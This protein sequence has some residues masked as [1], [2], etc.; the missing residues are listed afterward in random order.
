MHRRKQT[1]WKRT[2]QL[3]F[4]IS[5]RLTKRLMKSGVIRRVCKG[6]YTV[7]L[8][9][10]ECLFRPPAKSAGNHAEDPPTVD[11]TSSPLLFL[12]PC[13]RTYGCRADLA[14]FGVR[15]TA[16]R[17]RPT[18]IRHTSRVRLRAADP[19]IESQANCVIH[20]PSVF[21]GN[22]STSVQ[23]RFFFNFSLYYKLQIVS[24]YFRA[25]VNLSKKKKKNSVS[26]GF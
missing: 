13:H 15:R 14:R 26:I 16:T 23:M 22:A 5:F 21:C 12:V 19:I 4:C 20:P 17:N 2:R 3:Y 25:R 8:A 18:V 24:S 9:T 10:V 1:D 6:L 7:L 11:E